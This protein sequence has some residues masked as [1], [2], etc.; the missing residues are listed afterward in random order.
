MENLV[1]FCKVQWDMVSVA[2]EY[3]FWLDSSL[4]GF[5]QLYYKIQIFT[6]LEG[7]NRGGPGHAPQGG[8]LLLL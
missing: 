6:L 1:S 3:N 2:T 8:T 7:K 4:F 5:T